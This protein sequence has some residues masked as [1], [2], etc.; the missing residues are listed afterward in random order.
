MFTLCLRFTGIMAGDEDNPS[1]IPDDRPRIIWKHS[2]LRW[3]LK[4]SYSFFLLA[5]IAAVGFYIY[6][7]WKIGSPIFTSKNATQGPVNDGKRNTSEDQLEDVEEID[8]SVLK[9]A[10]AFVEHSPFRADFFS[11][12]DELTAGHETLIKKEQNS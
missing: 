2:P 4:M 12:K 11:N 7:Y 5:E 3:N 9:F 6:E 1:L 8:R 10:L